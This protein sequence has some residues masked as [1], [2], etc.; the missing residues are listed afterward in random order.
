MSESQKEAPAAPILIKE[1]EEGIFVARM[2][3]PERMN[4]M[5]GGLREALTDADYAA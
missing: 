3:R 5:D 1:R 2:N 4:A